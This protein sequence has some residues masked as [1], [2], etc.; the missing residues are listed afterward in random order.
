MSL[1]RRIAN[2]A[3]QT[4][5]DFR[6]RE[7][8]VISHMDAD[9][10]AAAAVI[11]LALDR[12]GIEHRVKFVRML[13]REVVE[14]LEP[15]ELTIFTDLGSSQ[16][17]NLSR[18]YSGHH[19]I[20]ADHHL[21]DAGF[22]WPELVHFNAHRMGIDGMQDISGAGMAYFIARELS[23]KNKDLA[24]IALVGALGDV[25][26][27][28]GSLTGLNTEIASDA[29]E[30]GLVKKEHDL[31]LYGRHSRPLFKALENFNDPPIPGVSGSPAGCVSMLK[32][33]DIPLKSGDRWRRLVDLS[34]AEKQ[35]LASE[36]I[37]RIFLTVPPE[38]AS[39][40]PRSI[41]G[42]VYSL[43]QEEDN[44]LLKDAE[45]F[46]T[47]LNSTA[48]HEQPVL[49]LEV[50]KGD[51]GVYYRA[52]LRLIRYHRRQIAQGLEF[53]ESTGLSEGPRKYLQYFDAT[54]VIKET[55]VGTLTSMALGYQYSNPFR[56]I[57][58]LVRSDG[59]A[60]ISA[61][62]SKLLFLR[63]LNM[64][65]AIREAAKKVGG[66][67]GGHAVACGAQIEEKFLPEFLS[68]FEEIM[69]NQLAQH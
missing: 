1:L 42:E 59:V 2:R 7:V 18:K 16:L 25:Q 17:E 26:N 43:T 66:E 24:S 27:A 11:S 69:L 8:E 6:N 19:V 40:V 31:L 9:G 47:C 21:P 44:S 45:E 63:G 56:P 38:L 62:C 35:K 5:R 60:K 51:R 65:L 15:A 3:A 54:G 14:D 37:A 13:Y 34:L 28:W 29:I 4:I 49:G 36:L 48:R 41:M 64:G 46:A 53:I 57:V 23:G 30:M 33:L 52:M 50:A 67:G 68:K 58:G 61:R 55:F 12:E 10:V 20:I 39:Y 22:E 32:Q